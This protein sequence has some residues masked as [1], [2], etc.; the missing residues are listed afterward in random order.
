MATWQQTGLDPAFAQIVSDLRQI[1]E[2]GAAPDLPIEVRTH[3]V[4]ATSRVLEVLTAP[5]TRKTA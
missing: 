2:V 3:A 5:T 1:V 4:R